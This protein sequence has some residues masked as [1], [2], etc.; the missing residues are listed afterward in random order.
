[1]GSRRDATPGP[2]VGFYSEPA[3]CLPLRPYRPKIVFRGLEGSIREV[4]AR[5]YPESRRYAGLGHIRGGMCGQ[6]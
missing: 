6:H 1:M 3:V 2:H 4:L 5:R